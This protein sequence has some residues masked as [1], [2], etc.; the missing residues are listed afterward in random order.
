MLSEIEHLQKQISEIETNIRLIE[1]RKTEYVNQT[2]IP[3]NLIKDEQQFQGRLKVLRQRLKERSDAATHN[4]SASGL[5][6][7]ATKVYV[8]RDEEKN[9]FRDMIYGQTEIHI[10]LIEAESG[11]GKTI[12]LDQ[13][14]EISIG[15]KCVRVDFKDPSYSLGQILGKMRD[16]YGPHSFTTFHK[17]CRNLLTQFGA[18]TEHP[19]LICSKIDAQL[20]KMSVDDRRDHQQVITDAFLADL[21]IIHVTIQQPIVML[22]DVFENASAPIKTWIA[23]QLIM[24]TRR[25]PWLVCVIAG[26]QTPRIVTDGGDWCLQ[27]RLQRLSDEHSREYIQK[28]TYTQDE[29]IVTVLTKLAKGS[30][31]ALQTFVLAYLEE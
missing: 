7:G 1:L 30:P 17:E 16:K 29:A 5:P 20:N 14:E 22:F 18:D 4:Q 31:A 10:L 19:A 11:M 9:L 3:L 26:Q 27:H 8:D 23:K 28:V 2:D 13:F 24:Q 12:L 25:Y 6:P 15:F 21:E